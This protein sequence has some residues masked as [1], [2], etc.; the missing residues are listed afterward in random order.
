MVCLE[1]EEFRDFFFLSRWRKKKIKKRRL[2]G[3][4]EFLGASAAG[5]E[6]SG[7]GS[8]GK[9]E[10]TKQVD[11]ALEGLGSLLKS[12]VVTGSGSG[13]LS[14]SSMPTT[15]AE[16]LRS[17]SLQTAQAVLKLMRSSVKLAFV[18]QVP[19]SEQAVLATLKALPCNEGRDGSWYIS[20]STCEVVA[21]TAKDTSHPRWQVDLTAGPKSVGQK[22]KAV[23]SEGEWRSL[24]DVVEGRRQWKVMAHHIAYNAS[25]LRVSAPLPLDCGRG[26]SIS[27]PCDQRGCLIHVEATPVHKDNMDRQR[28]LGILLLHFRGVITKEVPCVHGCKLGVGGEHGEELGFGGVVNQE[29]EILKSQLRRSCLKI[30]LLEISEADFSNMSS[31]VAFN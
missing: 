13:Q 6:D 4:Q 29:S 28:C 18:S 5:I 9:V 1:Q 26:G 17:L 30:R 15:E 3:R 23:L 10:G 8:E 16:W 24:L 21:T 22:L 2:V 31:L 20:R 19:E 25:D 14:A 27:H 12:E 7:S 11:G